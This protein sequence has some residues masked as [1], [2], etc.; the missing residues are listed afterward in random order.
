MLNDL[1]QVR[2]RASIR[3]VGLELRSHA[4]LFKPLPLLTS[5]YQSTVSY[6]SPEII[7]DKNN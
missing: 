6:M 4:F 2:E 3:T 7:L 5:E 1:F